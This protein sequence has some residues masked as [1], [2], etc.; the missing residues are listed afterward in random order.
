[1]PARPSEPN[2][3]VPAAAA[4]MI[5]SRSPAAHRPALRD[6][7]GVAQICVQDEPR[8]F[9]RGDAEGQHAGEWLARFGPRL[10]RRNKQ[11]KERRE[12]RD[13]TDLHAKHTLSA[14]LLTSGETDVLCVINRRGDA[15]S[16]RAESAFGAEL[17]QAGR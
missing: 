16:A 11:N 4:A 10:L 13:P 15:P 2:S 9:S 8:V 17:S 14:G 5:Q 3:T 6:E 1:M 12:A 7:H